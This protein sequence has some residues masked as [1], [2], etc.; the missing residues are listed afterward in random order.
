MV[1]WNQKIILGEVV[2]KWFLS[3]LDDWP[4]KNF[5]WYFLWENCDR[6]PYIKDRLLNEY[7][8][9]QTLSYVLLYLKYF[10]IRLLA[11]YFL[12]LY[13]HRQSVYF[14]HCIILWRSC[15]EHSFTYHSCHAFYDCIRGLSA[16][17]LYFDFCFEVT[18]PFHQ[19]FFPFPTYQRLHFFFHFHTCALNTYC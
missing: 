16:L 4:A 14:V 8:K 13:P 9:G 15:S 1:N 18:S 19:S 2:S 12:I 6:F 7:I 10:S 17:P 5:D 11:I 3:Y